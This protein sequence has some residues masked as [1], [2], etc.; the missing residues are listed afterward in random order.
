M[1][2]IGPSAVH[3][4]IGRHQPILRLQLHDG[5]I[6]EMP[7]HVR[8]RSEQ[9]RSDPVHNASHGASR[10]QSQHPQDSGSHRAP[11]RN[12]WH[13]RRRC[14]AVPK[15]REG[16]PSITFLAKVGPRYL[17]DD[18]E[19]SGSARVIGVR[20]VHLRRHGNRGLEHAGDRLLLGRKDDLRRDGIGP[21]IESV[22]PELL[23]AQPPVGDDDGATR[24]ARLDERGH[25]SATKK[26]IRRRANSRGRSWSVPGRDVRTNL[27]RSI[28][29]MSKS[30]SS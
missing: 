20:D 11:L 9:P 23:V 29:G 5:R 12:R 1:P 2:R 16:A 17:G 21:R 25:P 26:A 22:A 24:A 13:C 8:P 27:P 10:F 18:V 28:R 3:V 15:S 19:R 6:G 4:D 30:C 14:P 7:R